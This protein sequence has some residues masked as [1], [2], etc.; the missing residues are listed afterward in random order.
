MVSVITARK[1]KRRSSFEGE[2]RK[3]EMTQLNPPAAMTVHWYIQSLV[4]V[5]NV[6]V[7]EDRRWFNYR[8][9]GL[10]CGKFKNFLRKIPLGKSHTMCPLTPDQKAGENEAN[11]AKQRT[12]ILMCMSRDFHSKARRAQP[13]DRQR[14][15]MVS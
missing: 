15:K 11:L 5:L 12:T 2:R 7:R 14:T 9:Y 8:A 10:L 4:L 3:T 6:V 13:R 1:R